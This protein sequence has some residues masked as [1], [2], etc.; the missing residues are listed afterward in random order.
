VRPCDR[1]PAFVWVRQRFGGP[2][3]DDVAAAV[4]EG[5]G[6]A[7][8]AL[9]ERVRP[10]DTVAVAVGSRGITDLVAAVRATV[11]TLGGAGAR[12]FVVPAMGS[13]GGATAAGQEAILTALGVTEAS[14]GC[15]VR[16]SMAV[17]PVADSPLGH[18]LVVDRLAAE[19]DHVVLCNRIKPHTTFAGPVESGL[20]KMLVIGLGK[21]E[22]ATTAHRASLEHGFTAMLAAAAPVL[23]ERCRVLAG[24]ALVER[25]DDRTAVVA[26]V[27]GDRIVEREPALL[28]TARSLLPRL[29]FA[30]ADVLLVDRIGKD[31]SGTGIDTNV[32]GRKLAAPDP[33]LHIRHVVVRGLTEATGGNALGLGFADLCRR[34][35]V[36]RLDPVALRVNAV[37]AANL[38]A[39]R[40]PLTAATDAELLDV[41]LPLI[42]LRPPE[43]ARIQ[44]IRDTAHLERVACSVT[45]LDD[46]AGRDDLEILGDPWAL[47]L[48]P[49]GNLP[50]DAWE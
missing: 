14:V 49:D 21:A 9:G 43:S 26:V 28:A 16:S 24:V 36:E 33:S 15:P 2:V 19:A 45:Y 37:T 41:A 3:V 32:V 46:A 8:V 5:L 6:S 22:G 42:G 39:A 1:A 29:P 7:E 17:A 23:V 30:D 38:G 50:D 13:H 27:P 12:P 31:V 48:G 11:A 25:G 44:W 10:G 40:V 35:V 20:A 47:P 18:P 34:R 4:A